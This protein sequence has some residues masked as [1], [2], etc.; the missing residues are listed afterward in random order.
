MDYE[1]FEP[2]P[3][4]E[5]YEELCSAAWLQMSSEGWFDERGE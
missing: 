3:D 5:Y 1:V 4:D 2:D